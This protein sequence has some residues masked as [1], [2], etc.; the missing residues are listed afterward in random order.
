MPDNLVA[1]NPRELRPSIIRRREVENLTSLA[2]STL[3]AMMARGEFLRPIRIGVHA[4]GWLHS[5]VVG[6][7]LERAADRDQPR[8]RRARLLSREAQHDST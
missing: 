4:V 2:R 8:S 7:I 1:F 6:W 3:Y 5:E